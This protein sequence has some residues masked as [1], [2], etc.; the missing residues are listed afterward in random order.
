[1]EKNNYDVN[2]INEL[3]SQ[4]EK[5]VSQDNKRIA[6]SCII[7]FVLFILFFALIAVFDSPNA[8]KSVIGFTAILTFL[9]TISIAYFFTESKFWSAIIGIIAVIAI[10]NYENIVFNI[11]KYG[12]YLFFYR[13]FFIL[14]VWEC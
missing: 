13:L 2:L 9:V 11:I 14:L 6:I 3:E 12:T 4:Q 7:V 5:A 1:M 8:Q 10:Y